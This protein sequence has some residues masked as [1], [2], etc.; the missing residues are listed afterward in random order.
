MID[1][2]AEDSQNCEN[3]DPNVQAG[4]N[5][6]KK[7]TKIKPPPSAA[8]LQTTSSD[9]EKTPITGTIKFS[10]ISTVDLSY[11]VKSTVE[12]DPN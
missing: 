7:V 6:V 2:G 9:E 8:F 1:L 5:R 11:M 10:E 3:F 4:K 12:I